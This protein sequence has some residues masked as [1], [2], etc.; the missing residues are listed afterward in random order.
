MPN[1]PHLWPALT[2]AYHATT[3]QCEVRKR[4]GGKVLVTGI[5]R[6]DCRREQRRGQTW[7]SRVMSADFSGHTGLYLADAVTSIASAS[8]EDVRPGVL[9]R[10]G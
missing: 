6:R 1:L 3:K 2:Q 10:L 7:S 4:H 5:T 8:D 9:V